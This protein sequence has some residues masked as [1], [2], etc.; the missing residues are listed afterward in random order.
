MDW[1]RNL[2]TP[3][4]ANADGSS[5]TLAFEG[6]DP[7][8]ALLSWIVLG[9]LLWWIHGRLLT[10]T[11]RRKRILIVG[12]RL[13]FIGALLFTVTRPVLVTTL[14]EKVRQKLIVLVDASA[15]MDLADL[16]AT[17]EDRA[18]ALIASGKLAP[19][20]GP[21]AD[22]PVSEA[23]PTR[24]EVLKSLAANSK[25]DLWTKLDERAE[26]TFYTFGNDATEAPPPAAGQSGAAIARQFFDQ[27]PASDQ[28]TALGESL[29][30]VID[31]HRG[32][33]LAGVFIIT[34]GANNR[35]LAPSEAAASARAEGVPLF[36]YGVGVTEPRDVAVTSADAP[37]IAFLKE[38]VT[39]RVRLTA[40]GYENL[41]I[42]LTLRDPSDTAG[43]T[44]AET[45]VMLPARG[46]VDTELSFTPDKHGERSLEVA[47]KPLEGE[48][49]TENNVS[50]VRIRVIDNRVRVF[51]IEQ[52]PRWDWRYLLDFLQDDRRL[53]LQCV[54]LDGDPS[55]LQLPNTP[56]LEKLPDD[57]STLY[58][59][60]IILLGDVDPA[61]LGQARM[62]LIREWVDQAGGGLVF[63]AGPNHNPR[64]Y[65]GTP[66][67]PLL[68]VVPLSG[69]AD[70]FSA[71]HPEPANLVLTSAGARSPLLRLAENERDNSAAWRKFAGVR[72]TAKVARARPGAEVLLV[73][74]SASRTTPS[75]P[76]PVLAR[77][78]FGRGEVM[79]FGFNE[80]YRWRSEIGGKYYSQ[81]WSQIFQ[82]LSLERLS[83]ASKQVQLRVDRPEYQLGE[84]VVISGRLYQAD[85]KPLIADVVPARASRTDADAALLPPQEVMLRPVP[86]E[87]GGYRA[88]FSPAVAGRYAFSTLL[89]PSAVVEFDVIEPRLEQADA[90]MN[91]AL[92]D[93]TATAGGGRLFREENLFE[94]PKHV[95]QKGG[96][97]TSFKRLELAYSPILLALLLLFASAEWL[98]RR[99][100]RLK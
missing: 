71:R 72:W 93:A 88:E 69:P 100:N 83:G 36:L 27:L 21:A 10:S 38:K 55:L 50:S 56:F 75:G 98:V 70:E 53:T 32:E 48:A 73:D 95:E 47:A 64:S 46:G 45:T 7:G 84:R 62:Q 57:R 18:R 44:L 40:N 87:A 42:I 43:G 16:R 82:A 49:S 80:T 81:I 52:E 85:F 41:P 26:L 39:V 17:P 58:D 65:I 92:L 4:S 97:V 86:D 2:F 33:P 54:L 67:E 74:P 68:P 78:R 1:L 19:D 9:L 94:L 61:R 11:P 96:S 30:Q 12:L 6:L 99:L 63:L 31:R 23:R 77:Q 28:T 60:D 24:R 59:S 79:Y 29:R 8:W 35:G 90:A 89:D 25:L 14:V 5:T 66:L 34:D 51:M 3:G 15:S 22:A 76:G 20:A 13:L 37:R 91:L